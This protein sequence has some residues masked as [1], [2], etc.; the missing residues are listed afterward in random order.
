MQILDDL[1][2]DLDFADQEKLIDDGV[3]DSFDLISLI[4]EINS[5]FGVSINVTH[6]TPDNFN[7]VKSILMLIE[8]LK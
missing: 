3:L 2:P 6:M 1:R 7:S 8:R 4:S 5:E